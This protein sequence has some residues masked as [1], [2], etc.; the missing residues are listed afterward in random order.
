MPVQ[1]VAAQRSGGHPWGAAHLCQRDGVGSARR[2][3]R[4]RGMPVPCTGASAACACLLRQSRSGHSGIQMQAPSLE[5][6]A[7]GGG[8][9]AT[10]R[11]VGRMV[12]SSE[13][14]RGQRCHQAALPTLD[15]SATSM[16]TGSLPGKRRRSPI[17][18]SSPG[19]RLRLAHPAQALVPERYHVSRVP[20]RDAMC[21]PDM[22]HH[23]RR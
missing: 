1:S 22:L 15:G 17:A 10:R 3:L 4:Q 18:L 13:E 11:G 12:R 19:R 5:H 14:H 9:A 2:T 7:A 8:L 20:Y 23:N 21:V 6:A 16:A